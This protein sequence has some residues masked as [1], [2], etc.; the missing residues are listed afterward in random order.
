MTTKN[1]KTYNIY[2]KF[3]K[4]ENI[5]IYGYKRV[6]REAAILHPL[7]M[8]PL[9]IM[10][11]KPNTLF[12]GTFYQQ[13]QVKRYPS[14]GLQKSVWWSETNRFSFWEGAT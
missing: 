13:K 7:H 14:F 1:Q 10:G 12:Y 9:F 3:A 6:S 11:S 5:F 4:H 8:L 2:C